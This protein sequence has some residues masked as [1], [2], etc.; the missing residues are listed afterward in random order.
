MASGKRRGSGAASKDD[1]DDES[2]PLK[3]LKKRK[4]YH[5]SAMYAVYHGLK[6]TL[7]WVCVQ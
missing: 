7:N 5:F 6:K 3:D 4:S 2:T 1:N